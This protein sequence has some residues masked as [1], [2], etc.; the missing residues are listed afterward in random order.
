MFLTNNGETVPGRFT[1]SGAVFE[2]LGS[3]EHLMFKDHQIRYKARGQGYTT[4]P[5]LEQLKFKAHQIS[6][7][8]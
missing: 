1:V 3:L 7:K 5:S 6:H 8:P 2:H 4:T